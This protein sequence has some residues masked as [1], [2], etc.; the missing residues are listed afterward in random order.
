MNPLNAFIL[1]AILGSLLT[2]WLQ[3]Q[4]TGKPFHPPIPVRLNLHH[5][6]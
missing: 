4:Q 1:G 3:S 6:I 2:A 5:R